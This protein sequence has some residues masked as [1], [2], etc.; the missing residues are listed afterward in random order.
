MS[1]QAKNTLSKILGTCLDTQLACTS[2]STCTH[3]VYSG[4]RK[5]HPHCDICRHLWFRQRTLQVTS[6]ITLEQSLKLSTEVPV[7]NRASI[8]NGLVKSCTMPSIV[9]GRCSTPFTFTSGPKCC[10]NTPT[11]TATMMGDRS[12]SLARFTTR[13]QRDSSSELPPAGDLPNCKSTVVTGKKDNIRQDSVDRE[14]GNHLRAD[15]FRG[16]RLRWVECMHHRGSQ[17]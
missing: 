11:I 7:I 10:Q 3:T 13:S 16:M 2:V 4:N 6:S 5:L 15:T 12:T 17:W 14:V 8:P 1:A 9:D